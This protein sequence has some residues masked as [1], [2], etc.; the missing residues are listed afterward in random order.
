[1]HEIKRKWQNVTWLI[2][3]DISKYFDTIHH[4]TLLDLAKPY[5]DQATL[6]LTG[7]L[8][9]ANYVDLSNISD[10]IERR[11]MGTPSGSLI[12][13]MLANIYLHELDKF[14]TNELLPKWNKGDERKYVAGYQT[15]NLLT[16]E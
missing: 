11:F 1:L 4:K 7:K 14:I 2:N 5:C 6:E 8:L 13:P 12:S 10:T 15:R 16:S 3:I 9:K